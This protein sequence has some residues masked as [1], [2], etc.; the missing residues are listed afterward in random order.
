MGWQRAQRCEATRQAA[1]ISGGALGSAV[2][3]DG[4]RKGGGVQA[5]ASAMARITASVLT[6][7][8]GDPVADELDLLVRQERRAVQRHPRAERGRRLELLDEDAGAAIALNDDVFAADHPTR[9][10][11]GVGR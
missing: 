4:S 5:A 3:R 9:A 10:Q 1:W 7:S 8:L 2:R 6:S 11:P